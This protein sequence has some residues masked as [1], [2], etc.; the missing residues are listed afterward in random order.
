MDQN[1][2]GTVVQRPSVLED[3]STTQIDEMER[4]FAE[5]DRGE[6]NEITGSYGWTQAQSDAVWAWFGQRPSIGQGGTGEVM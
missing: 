3:L 4:Q 5:G 2:N 6:W 1:V